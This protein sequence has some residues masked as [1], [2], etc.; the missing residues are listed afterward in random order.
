MLGINMDITDLK[1]AEG[2]VAEAN[3]QLEAILDSI[4]EPVMVTDAGGNLVRINAA[5]KDSV[6]Y[7][8]TADNYVGR[9]EA[10]T[11]DGQL[12]PPEDWPIN[13]V[14][15]GE[16]VQQCDVILSIDGVL[17]NRRFSGSPVR[18]EY[19]NVTHAVVAFFDITDQK[20]TAQAL[21]R[22]RNQL[23]SI[24]DNLVDAVFV[25][26]SDGEFV[27]ANAAAKG[28]CE[29]NGRIPSIAECADIFEL[30]LPDGQV[31]PVERWPAAAA[32]RGE[33]VRNFEVRV[34]RK[35]SG[36]VFYAHFWAA[37]I[38]DAEGNVVQVAVSVHDLTET[39]ILAG[40]CPRALTARAF[41]TRTASGIRW[42]N[43]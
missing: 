14:R 17:T 3:A 22:S 8:T 21:V 9:V 2:A 28:L 37:P 23:E 5:F 25:M 40:Y 42:S 6:P 39:K 27:K 41:G 4:P 19:G 29:L 43:I 33:V 15:R 24:L 7:E 26:N 1:R 12:I 35:D 38:R 20:R 13:R 18:N 10:Y 30:S 36:K 32:L 31:L 11:D 34:R 16:R